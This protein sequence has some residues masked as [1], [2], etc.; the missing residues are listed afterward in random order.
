MAD[1]RNSNSSGSSHT[2][3]VS[4][5]TGSSGLTAMAKAPTGRV[6][7]AK[8]LA[9]LARQSPSFWQWPLCMLVVLA[10]RRVLVPKLASGFITLCQVPV[11]PA[12]L[13]ASLWRRKGALAVAG[14]LTVLRLSAVNR[15]LQGGYTFDAF[16]NHP[17]W[18]WARAQ[19]KSFRILGNPVLQK[20]KHVLFCC[21]PHGTIS[22][23]GQ[24]LSTVPNAVQKLCGGPVEQ[25]LRIAVTHVL[26]KMPFQQNIT[27][28]C[29]CIPA[30][31]DAVKAAFDKNS[32]VVIFP[33]VAAEAGAADG[34]RFDGTDKLYVSDKLFASMKDITASCGPIA[35]VPVYIHGES[36][37]FRSL[38]LVPASLTGWFMRKFQF[39]PML[40]A[41]WMNLPIARPVD[42]AVAVGQPLQLDPSTDL[43]TLSK[44]YKD[45]LSRVFHSVSSGKVEISS[46][47]EAVRA[48][49][50]L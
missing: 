5:A 12:M 20:E 34:S 41:G 22:L 2:L 30:R 4:K 42:Y 15:D 38:P 48:M 27:R 39:V 23:A 49:S 1:L 14:L 11:L 29:G 43:A 44:G 37:A 16:R 3:N 28:W 35:V 21:H 25:T 36:A 46:V 9:F 24:F 18:R 10:F 33:G 31:K 17:M 26:L 13:C 6:W 19:M 40:P 7:Q 50:K 32:H 8:L 47:E 45:E